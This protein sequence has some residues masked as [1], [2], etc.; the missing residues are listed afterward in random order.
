[1]ECRALLPEQL[2]HTTKLTR[3]YV[4]N[5]S[6]LESFYGH[7]PDLHSVL[8]QARGLEFPVER[9]REVADILRSQNVR[10]G[11]GEK[12][13]ENLERLSNQAVTVVSGQQVGLFGGP[14]YAF[15]KALT[16]I[17]AARQLTRDG[18]DAVPVFWMAT[19]DHDVDEV[20]HTTWFREGRLTRFELPKPAE[21]D[22]PVGRI[23]L[24]PEISE[25][26]TEASGMLSGPDSEM[27]AEIL[28][29]SYTPT[30]T[31][32]TAFASLFARIFASEGLILLDPLDERL[33]RVAAPVLQQGLERR[34]ELNTLL[35]QRGKELEHAGYTAQVNVTSTSTVL[36]SL[37]GGKRRVLSA[38][39]GDTFTCAGR[40]APRHEWVEDL[41]KNP[42]LFSPNALFRPIVQ[43]FM[44]PTVVYFGGPAEIA[45]FAQS[46]VL[47]ENLLGRMPIILPRADFTLVD[48][49]AVRILKKYGMEVEDVWEGKQS[50]R[51][52][53]YGESVPK[54]LAREF[55][56]NLRQ[57]ENGVKKLHKAIAKVDP[58]I[59]GTVARAE[60]RIHYQIEKL[61]EKTGAAL[62]RHG[63]LVD[64][65]EQ[66]LENL[67]YPQKG[68]QSRDLSFLPFL[69][70]WGSAGLEELEKHAS[71][72]KPG[73]HFLVPIP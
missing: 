14:S 4:T 19:E 37:Q 60:K 52:R 36:F 45:Y 30:S 42:E 1:M 32:G 54:K 46:H 69:A 55:D 59:Q 31:Y 72:R 28:Q 44:L 62:D 23:L 68:L 48:P 65:H 56:T 57:M 5:F 70:R 7:P 21:T 20:R 73:V 2:P 67:L 17:H 33:H 22:I 16:A 25:V 8:T 18:I 15:Y 39:N 27:L 47:Y 29:E 64:R 53:M 10:F 6:R 34:D 40:T 11:S 58:T 35:L 13:L 49:K 12:T 3:D 26:V 24:G 41:E 50:L 38:S 9:R 66:F 43:D 61:R 51:K 71:T 63:K